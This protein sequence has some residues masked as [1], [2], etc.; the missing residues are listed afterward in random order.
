M[1]M[2]MTLVNFSLR[3][4][5]HLSAGRASW[6]GSLICRDTWCPY[7]ELPYGRWRGDRHG[8][9]AGPETES[10]FCQSPSCPAHR[11]RPRLLS[12]D[13]NTVPAS[14]TSES[15]DVCLQ[16]YRGRYVF[17]VPVLSRVA[18]GFASSLFQ[19]RVG[20]SPVSS[21]SVPAKQNRPPHTVAASIH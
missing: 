3:S 8:R 18:G 14:W 19:H 4:T 7:C 17:A 12:R 2:S 1:V 16:K 6:V 13:D 15:Y 9:F 11:P 5:V 20:K 10:S 21:L